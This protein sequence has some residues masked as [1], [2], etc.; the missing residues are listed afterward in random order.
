MTVTVF[1][2]TNVLLYALD[3]AD[4]KKQEA[5]LEW[6]AELWKRRLG[7]I[8]FQVLQEFYAKSTRKWP[9]ARDDL[10]SE[11]KNLLTWRPVTVDD[12]TLDLSWRIQDRYQLSFWDSAH[13]GGREI[14][15]LPVSLD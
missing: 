1:V 13:R 8:S 11:I 2:D 3:P 14:N 7:R 9:G 10:R 5:A 6:Q 12:A 15:Q 4:L